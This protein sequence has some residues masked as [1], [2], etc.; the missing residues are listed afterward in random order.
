MHQACAYEVSPYVADMSSSYKYINS[1][2]M[3]KENLHPLMDALGAVGGGV[4]VIGGR[5]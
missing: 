4:V 3:A 2:K 5:T 1:E